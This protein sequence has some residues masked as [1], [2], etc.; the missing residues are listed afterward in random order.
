[1]NY[2]NYF[3]CLGDLHPYARDKITKIPRLYK[4]KKLFRFEI[5]IRETLLF[6]N[7]DYIKLFRII[8]HVRLNCQYVDNELKFRHRELFG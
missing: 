7:P 1:M 3:S 2:Q 6:L 8:Y 5:L 4:T